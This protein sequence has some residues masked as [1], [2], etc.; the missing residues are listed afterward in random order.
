MQAAKTNGASVLALY[1]QLANNASKMMDEV[2]PYEDT[3]DEFRKMKCHTKVAN[4]LDSCHLAHSR[5]HEKAA[6]IID[7]DG[8]VLVS[9][10]VH[11][12]EPITSW[13]LGFV[14]STA[15][16]VQYIVSCSHTLE[17]VNFFDIQVL[18][19]SVNSHCIMVRQRIHSAPQ[20]LPPLRLS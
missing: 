1:S 2:L 18:L 3:P 15:E 4:W 8:L 20:A 6:M 19:C 13:S 5:F 12:K 16:Q 9:H 11:G 14:I 17:S 7:E 10:V